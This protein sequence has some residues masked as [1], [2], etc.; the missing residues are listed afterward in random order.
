MKC[1]MCL[2]LLIGAGCV[3]KAHDPAAAP[4][5]APS[6]ATAGDSIGEATM[7]E[8]GTLVLQLRAEGP[9]GLIGDGQVTYAPDHPDYQEVIDHLGGIRPGQKKPVP[10]WPD[11]ER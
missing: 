9:A 8:D 5:P 11:Q 6:E 2:A 3:S 7:R 4:H 10:P 1:S